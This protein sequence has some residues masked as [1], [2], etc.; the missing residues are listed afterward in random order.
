M[1]YNKVSLDKQVYDRF[2]EGF[3]L[4]NYSAGEILDPAE[5]AESYGVS[6]T[7]V[8][9]ALRKLANENI[10][11][12]H[13]NG[14]FVIPVPRENI[15]RDICNT[16]LF[17]EKAAAEDIMDNGF[18]EEAY[19]DLTGLAFQGCDEYTAQSD[20]DG[21]INDVNFHRRLVSYVSNSCIKDMHQLIFNR[22]ISIRFVL[23]P[24]CEL[25]Q[26]AVKDHI[27]LIE[28]M[29]ANN[30]EKTFQCLEGHIGRII[31][32][33]CSQCRDIKEQV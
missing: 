27:E 22:F 2:I 1:M 12:I 31:P 29:K 16:W 11:E 13:K 7:P 20:V 26:I 9:H 32:R 18:S 24:V 19:K 25:Q 21:V 6:R 5:L 33:L 10:L 28:S 30:K 3:Y 23:R 17:L 15:V 14:R 4:K 8:V